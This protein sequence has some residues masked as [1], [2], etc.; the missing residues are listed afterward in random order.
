MSFFQNLPRPASDA[1][2][3]SLTGRLGEP[4]A[5]Y[6]MAKMKVQAMTDEQVLAHKQTP[7]FGIMPA[8]AEAPVEGAPR[9]NAR[10]QQASLETPFRSAP[11]GPLDA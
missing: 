5:A 6:L 4:G 11:K 7:G 8:I 2:N 9:G 1:A 3:S 10:I